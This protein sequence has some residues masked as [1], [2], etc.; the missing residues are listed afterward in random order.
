[1][2]QQ[3]EFYITYKLDLMMRAIDSNGNQTAFSG[4]NVVTGQ[5]SSATGTPDADSDSTVNNVSF[6]NGYSASE[7]DADTGDVIYLENRTPITR[8]SDQTENVKLI[9]EF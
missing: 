6:T 2:I 7:L 3:I 4:T 1:M 9:V 5:S 8:A